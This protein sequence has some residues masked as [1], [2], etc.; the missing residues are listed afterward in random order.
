MPLSTLVPSEGRL[1]DYRAIAVPVL[2]LGESR[3]SSHDGSRRGADLRNAAGGS[4]NPPAGD[5]QN[6]HQRSTHSLEADPSDERRRT[7]ANGDDA[8]PGKEHHVRG[9]N[10]AYRGV[11]PFGRLCAS[12]QRSAG[13]AGVSPFDEKVKCSDLLRYWRY[14][15]AVQA[16]RQALTNSGKGSDLR[17][18]GRGDR[19]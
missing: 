2:L 10:S 3:C 13:Q 17:K 9:L 14:F 15:V 12:L 5:H 1:P 6:P 8:G 19:I 18:H 4:G 11:V 16:A 7:E